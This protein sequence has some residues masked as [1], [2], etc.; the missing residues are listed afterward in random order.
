MPCAEHFRWDTASGHWNDEDFW[1]D[2][3]QWFWCTITDGWRKDWPSDRFGWNLRRL[4]N[5]RNDEW[6]PCVWWKTGSFWLMHC[7]WKLLVWVMVVMWNCCKLLAWSQYLLHPMIVLLGFFHLKQANALNFRVTLHR[8]TRVFCRQTSA[9]SSLLQK[10]DLPE[11]GNFFKAPLLKNT[12]WNMAARSTQQ[13]SRIVA[14]SWSQLLKT[15][16]LPFGKWTLE[17]DFGNLSIAGR[18][19]L[20]T[21][22]CDDQLVLTASEDGTARLISSD[23]GINCHTLDGHSGRAVNRAEFSP[24]GKLIVTASTDAKGCIWERHSGARTH[25]LQG[26]PSDVKHASFSADSRQVFL[27]HATG[28]VEVFCAQTGSCQWLLSDHVE[29]VY[30]AASCPTGRLVALGSEDARATVWDLTSGRKL[31]TLAEHTDAVT[32]ISWN[33]ADDGTLVTASWDG[34]VKLWSAESGECLDTFEDHAGPVIYSEFGTLR[35]WGQYRTVDFVNFG[36]VKVSAWRSRMIPCYRFQSPRCDRRWK[37][38]LWWTMVDHGDL[39]E[40]VLWCLK[41]RADRQA[42]SADSW[43]PIT[44]SKNS[45]A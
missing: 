27:T 34:T 14:T 31:W 13:C 16:V 39:R 36:W 21:F 10:M 40:A 29:P 38:W 26:C 18:V 7:P 20:A 6:Q 4:C 32:W 25:V 30:L 9:M 11:Y 44:N 41:V 17:N 28:V 1:Q 37:A 2:G 35:L 12:F 42:E 3:Y 22:S 23:D 15:I 8:S 19:Y 5:Q 33:P 43:K 24:D 45:M